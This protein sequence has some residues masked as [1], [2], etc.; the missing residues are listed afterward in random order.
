MN[1]IQPKRGFTLIELLVVITI[2]GILVGLL[3]PAV[4]MAREAARRT[5]CSNNL[6]QIGL[7]IH[8]HE[9]SKKYLPGNGGYTPTSTIKDRSGNP[10]EITTFDFAEAVLYQ[11]GIGVPGA[12]PKE[13]PGSWGYAVL[14]Y[15]EQA[16]AYQQLAIE[17]QPT[18][19]LCPSR[20]R[21]ESLPTV[22]DVHGSYVSGGWAWSKSDYAGN[23]LAI[24][25]L[26]YARRI[27]EITDGLSNTIAIGEKAFNTREQLPSSWYWDEPLFAGGSDSTVRDGLRLVQDG[28]SDYRKNWGSA[29]SNVTGFVAIDGAVHWLSNSVDQQVIKSFLTP[30][31]AESPSWDSGY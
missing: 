24:T 27:S 31:G 10:I 19:F 21:S 9:V 12:R 18:V 14:P 20:A 7:A 15:L 8:N 17:H 1:S 6:K 5:Q 16:D 22:D 30:N 25:N 3:L 4:Q 29:H 11:W 2:V 23:K 13:Q 26:P 28:S